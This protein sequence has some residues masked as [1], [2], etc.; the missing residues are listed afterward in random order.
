MA[1]VSEII[2]ESGTY[3]IKD[4]FSRDQINNLNELLQ[5]LTDNTQDIINAYNSIYV[6]SKNSTKYNTINKAIAAAKQKNVKTLILIMPGEYQEQIYL[7]ENNYIDLIGLDKNIT[8]IYGN[9]TYPDCT[10]YTDGSGLFK[11]LTFKNTNDDAYALHYDPGD[12][13]SQGSM[14]FQNCQFIANFHSAGI[15]LGMN[16]SLTFFNCD[17]TCLQNNN[18]LYAHNNMYSNRPGQNL[19]VIN[20]YLYT[21]G[22]TAFTFD[23][24][25]Y[26]AQAS[27]STCYLDFQNNSSNGT[28]F[29]F[30]KNTNSAATNTW[31][32]YIQDSD[33][34]K[35]LPSSHGNFAKG[36]NYG[37]AVIQYSCYAVKGLQNNGG[38]GTYTVI[39]VPV[40]LKDYDVS[41][42][43]QMVWANTGG[44]STA[45]I[46][47]TVGTAVTITDNDTSH[48]GKL[49]S[50]GLKL[51][52]K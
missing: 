41:I 1:D 7:R 20:C 46:W 48:Y 34:V 28:A 37:E 5:T 47:N 8:T 43:Q 49:F 24:A 36:I 45:S 33:T 2:I 30:R 19:R 9:Y 3:Q 23:D 10:L 21:N 12:N 15:G 31:V 17:F 42:Y 44:T 35:L 14:V 18:A 51:T 26:S 50:I 11:N 32:H 52:A 38:N 25:A 6:V 4:S 29:L 13:N 22:S 16:S 27:N 40:N 39:P